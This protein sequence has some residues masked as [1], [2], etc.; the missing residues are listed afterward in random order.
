MRLGPLFQISFFVTLG[1][2]ACC[3]ALAEAFFLPWLALTLPFLFGVFVLAWLKEGVWV[4][5]ETAA[6]YLGIVIALAASAWI[7]FHV[8]QTEEQILASGVPWPAGLLPQ[9]AP[10]LLLLLAVKLFRPKRLADFWVIQTIGLMMVTLGCVL[11]YQESFG[12][13]L[14]LYIASLLWCLMLFHFYQ[15]QRRQPSEATIT[16]FDPVGHGE[17]AAA[18]AM[19]WR[20]FGL[21]PIVLWLGMIVFTSM[22]VF[23]LLPRTGAQQWVP[24]KLSGIAPRSRKMQTGIEP[25]IDLFRVGHLEVSREEAFSVSVRDAH[26]RDNPAVGKPCALPAT[27]YWRGEVLDLYERGRW[28]DWRV[29][30]EQGISFKK[31]PLPAPPALKA[32]KGPE[33]DG[34]STIFLRL[35]VRPMRVGQL[36]MLAEPVERSEE[37]RKIDQVAGFE[38]RIGD[39][40]SRVSLFHRRDGCDELLPYVL[41]PR[42]VYQYW[43]ELRLPTDRERI[44]VGDVSDEYRVYLLEQP[45]PQDIREWT[46]ELIKHQ[47]GLR[48]EDRAFDSDDRL[49]LEAQGKV[50]RSL[51]RYLSTSGLFKYSLELRRKDYN[52]D[53]TVDFL[54]NTKQGH[55]ER[56]ASGLALMLRG[57]GIPARIIKGYRDA[58]PRTDGEDDEVRLEG[59]YMV[60]Q[61]QAHSWVQALVTEDGRWYWLNLDP[62]PAAEA[63]KTESLSPLAWLLTNLRDGRQFW[64]NFILEY[65][66]EVQIASAKTL[67]T[68]GE[69]AMRWAGR[70]V[71]WTLPPLVLASVG[72]YGARHWRRRVSQARAAAHGASG[73]PFYARYLQV[74][75]ERFH[76]LPQ[77]GQTPLEFN[78]L[79]ADVLRSDARYVAW[80]SLPARYT[81]ALY[82]LDYAGETL[83][84]TEQSSLREQLDQLER[85]STQANGSAKANGS[86]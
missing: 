44:P 1:L 17:T 27:I 16:L 31:V 39:R 73:P 83:S 38:A 9:L 66:N 21:P 8:P 30:V 86:A 75:A 69:R 56:Y 79:A 35:S 46:R 65:N 51:N 22:P 60:R 74:L 81:D 3:L 76:L 7:L 13:M 54:L 72:W 41:T 10:V 4:L 53:P 78:R 23:L 37:Q 77:L 11:A 47:P 82:R 12:V 40:D 55:C 50:A 36:L 52:A 64:N 58:E 2:A 62:T 32:A 63:A 42:Q 59:E 26:D 24:Q 33:T 48:D 67:K 57:L 70:S 34:G 71:A 45:V 14:L 28:Q 68:E 43:Q 19:P 84:A 85:A 61:A 80:V 6:N 49:Q 5:G 29:V 20:L 15:E 25:G 18:P